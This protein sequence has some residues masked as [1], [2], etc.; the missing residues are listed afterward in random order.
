VTLG[1][2]TGTVSTVSTAKNM[3]WWPSTTAFDAAGDAETSTSQAE[4]DNDVDF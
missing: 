1:S 4:I 3:V 2:T